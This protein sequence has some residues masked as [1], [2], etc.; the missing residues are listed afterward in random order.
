M[1][2]RLLRTASRTR[3]KKS[4]LPETRTSRWSQ[5]RGA[6]KVA[7]RRAVTPPFKRWQNGW[8]HLT[9][10]LLASC[11]GQRTTTQLDVR[12]TENHRVL[13]EQV[14]QVAKPRHDTQ[15]PFPETRT[16]LKRDTVG[17][18]VEVPPDAP[19]PCVVTCQPGPLPVEK[20]Y[21]AERGPARV[22]VARVARL[23]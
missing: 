5:R 17:V 13:V 2:R 6:E 4:G 20:M 18:P 8:R 11:V 23:P 16:S 10:G 14:E 15:G 1:S 21:V 22:Y 19:C 3:R 12:G 9:R 7:R